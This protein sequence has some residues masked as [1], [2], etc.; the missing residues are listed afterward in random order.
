MVS[1]VV[2]VTGGSRGIGRATAKRLAAEGIAIAVNYAR[3][4]SAAQ[5]TVRDIVVAGGSAIALRGDISDL[6]ANAAL[7]DEVV[8]R[9]GRL[10]ILANNAGIAKIGSF[11][12]LARHSYDQMAQI[13]R[14]TYF[15]MQSAMRILADGGRIIS[16]SSSLTRDWPTFMGAYA[17]SKSAI[18][19]LTRALSKE[20]GGRGIT[21][22]A[23]LPG[24]IR[25]DMA[26]DVPPDQIEAI[27]WSTSLDRIGKPEDIADVVAFLV[28]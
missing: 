5:A 12:S 23:I 1:R 20:A 27:R 21:V 28:D 19:Q 18:E 26:V 10:D 24:F 4:E 6:E 2:L 9:F 16:I 11:E 15:A 3:D 25:T 13:T 22:N 17:G 14:G 8:C 7:F